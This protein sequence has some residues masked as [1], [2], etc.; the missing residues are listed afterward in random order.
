M[1]KEAYIVG[2][3]PDTKLASVI[4]EDGRRIDDVQVAV[5]A[6]SA[7]GGGIRYE[8][9]IG[10]ACLIGGS[11]GDPKVIAFMG[12][13]DPETGSYDRRAPES[14]YGD[15]SFGTAA[16]NYIHLRRNGLIEIKSSELCQR[17]YIPTGAIIQ[18]H[19]KQYKGLCPGGEISMTARSSRT[20]EG[21][22]AGAVLYQVQCRGSALD[23]E[24]GV[25][26]RLGSVAGL[27]EVPE[28]SIAPYHTA[29]PVYAELAVGFGEVAYLFQVTPAGEA[30]E[31]IDGS[32]IKHV[33]GTEASLSG[34]VFKRV[35]GSVEMQTAGNINVVC[36]ADSFLLYRDSAE[37]YGG[38][39]VPEGGVT[40]LPVGGGAVTTE[41]SQVSRDCSMPSANA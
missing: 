6:T 37:F 32:H 22:G 39:Y 11:K 15:I 17:T 21:G 16:D 29:G 7:R 18:E 33:K 19:F 8:C 36:G 23:A 5:P 13:F 3:D 27:T 14:T 25:S 2:Y 34:A 20:E 40:T 26:F 28:A 38:V 10:D 35:E 12:V 9:T 30:V 41:F 4:I 1:I 24:M 31:R